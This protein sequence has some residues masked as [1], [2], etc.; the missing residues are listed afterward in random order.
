MFFIYQALTKPVLI[1]PLACDFAHL[2]LKV[3][4]YIFS[5]LLL[6]VQHFMTDK[7][8]LQIY[9]LTIKMTF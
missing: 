2:I 1:F 5:E 4:I 3:L 9:I 7:F 8:T 6:Y